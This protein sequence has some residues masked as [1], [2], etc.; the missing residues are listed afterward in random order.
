MWMLNNSP[1]YIM[2]CPCL[3]LSLHSTYINALVRIP[4]LHKYTIVFRIQDIHLHA[5]E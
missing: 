2:K 3:T 1:S 4:H 5:N